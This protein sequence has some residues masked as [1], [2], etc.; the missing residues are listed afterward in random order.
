M[1]KKFVN[2]IA[3]IGVLAVNYLANALPIN[4]KNTGELSDQYPNLFVPAGITFSI[5]GL[6]YLLLIVWVITQ[7][8]PRQ[9][10]RADLGWLFALS[11]VLNVSWIFLWHYEQPVI[12]VI[13]MG[14]LLRTLVAINRLLEKGEDRLASAAFGV[15]LGWICIA[16]IA[17][18]TAALVS[19]KWDGFGISE[20]LWTILLIAA[21]AGITIWLIRTLNN[22]FLA[23]S[24]AWAFV[25]IIL[26][27]Q[28]DF[29]A[30]AYAAGAGVILLATVVL[31][32]TFRQ[33]RSGVE[34]S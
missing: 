3:L 29:P 6:I 5:W 8:V 12:A 25:G 4:G 34:L 15:Y 23:F 9:T 14:W 30:I 33:Q 18:I 16:I 1:I 21:G 28:G 2:I 24:V 19:V 11:C 13:V 32:R 17:N 7:F 31:F 22:S 20:V 10:R 26:K 27:R